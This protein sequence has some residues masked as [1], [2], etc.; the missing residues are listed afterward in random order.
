MGTHS[1]AVPIIP[2]FFRALEFSAILQGKGVGTLCGRKFWTPCQTPDP[3]ISKDGVMTGYSDF[4]L[5]WLCGIDILFNVFLR[6]PWIVF[7][8]NPINS[9]WSPSH[10]SSLHALP[11]LSGRQQGTPPI[12]VQAN[13]ASMTS[14][15]ILAPEV[16]NATSISSCLWQW[17]LPHTTLCN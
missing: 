16:E 7:T 12:F 9:F 14:Q 6:E 4:T 10:I 2:F 15:E 11:S 13:R 3:R 17:K 1:A 8:P 5:L